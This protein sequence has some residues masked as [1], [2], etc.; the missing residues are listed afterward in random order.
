MEEGCQ[1]VGDVERGRLVVDDT[2]EVW[3]GFE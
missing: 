2:L 3:S 1:E